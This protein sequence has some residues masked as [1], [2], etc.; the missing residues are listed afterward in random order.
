MECCM[1]D[2][3]KGKAVEFLCDYLGIPI[4]E[5]VA[6]GDAAND[7]SMIKAAGIGVAMQN[8]TDDAKL[9]ADYITSN[10][11]NCDG[12]KEVLEKFLL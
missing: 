9:S 8:A 7:I 3:S 11:N 6:C 10:T 4:A 12:I 5:S 1:K 2:A